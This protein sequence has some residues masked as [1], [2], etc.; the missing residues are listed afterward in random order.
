MLQVELVSHLHGVVHVYQLVHE[1]H[2]VG[3]A[4]PVYLSAFNHHEEAVFLAL[5]LHEEVDARTCY[6]GQR[7]VVGTAVEG[8]GN[9][10]AVVVACL[11]ALEQDHA[12]CLC[13]LLFVVGISA[14]Y[15]ESLAGCL[16]VE[17]GHVG[18]LGVVG[19]GEV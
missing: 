2:V 3:V 8:V 11:L 12:L 13:C 18:M 6:L 7:E 17:V 10:V 15:G 14:C 5:L 4:S 16:L 19:N 1:S 9:A